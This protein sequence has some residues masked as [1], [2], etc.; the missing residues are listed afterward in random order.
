MIYVEEQDYVKDWSSLFP[1]MSQGRSGLGQAVA[2][3]A[4]IVTTIAMAC[5][6]G[7]IT[8]LIMRWAGRLQYR[9]ILPCKDLICSLTF[10]DAKDPF[11]SFPVQDD[12]F[13]FI[14]GDE[15]G[16]DIGITELTQTTEFPNQVGSLNT[17]S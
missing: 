2:Q 8:G 12:Q 17:F 3:S 10:R 6:G 9:Q 13:N 16:S 15:N 11:S 5:V 7:Y 4:A 14:N 1:A